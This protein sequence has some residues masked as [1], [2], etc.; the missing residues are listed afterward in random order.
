M[1]LGLP[2]AGLER[3]KSASQRA[4]VATE[5]WACES[6]YCPQCSSNRVKQFAANTPAIDFTCPNCDALFQLKSQSKPFGNRINDAAY[7]SMVS[8]IREDRTP[9]LLALHY[10][11][12]SWRVE[13]LLLIPRFA[14]TT[15]MIEKRAPLGPD[16]RRAGW[17]GCNILIGRVPADARISMVVDGVPAKART[18]REEYRRLAP[19]Q[20][21]GVARRGWTLDV[22][23]G[24]RSL[25]KT[26]F[27]L[28]DAYTL[29][30]EL[31]TLHPE[32]RHVRDKIRQQ[33]QVLRDMGLLKFLEAGHY[34]FA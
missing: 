28:A 18:V 9:N 7:A 30:R 29:E 19:L 34:R 21:L 22:L 4:R 5:A 13:N 12:D 32:N 23:S 25:R 11:F 2:V 6:L 31:Q 10:D 16:A 14:Y 26:E 20:K 8:A 33:L 17:V 24:L 3:Y 15:S 27:T 1:D